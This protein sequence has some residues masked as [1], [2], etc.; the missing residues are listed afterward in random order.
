VHETHDRR[1]KKLFDW[2]LE[3]TANFSKRKKE[4][5]KGKKRLLEQ[6]RSVGKNI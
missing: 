1:I 4:K 6:L 3:A 5:E 2:H